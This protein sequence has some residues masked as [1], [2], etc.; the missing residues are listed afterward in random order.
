M[1]IVLFS[2]T[3]EGRKLSEA[4]AS[5]GIR[6]TVCV[7]T[8]LGSEL[9]G[10]SGGVTVRTGRMDAE[11]MRAFFAT[12]GLCETDTVVD[13][14]HPYAQEVSAN[15]RQA[16]ESFGVR[17]LT[18][19]RS[20]SAVPEGACTYADMTACAKAMDETEGNILLTTGSKELETFFGTI[21]AE[22]AQRTYVRVLPVQES[23]RLCEA[24]GVAS[25]HVIAMQGPFSEE[26]NRAIMNRFGIRHLVTKDGGEA[27]GFPEKSAA[28]R[29]LGVRLHMIARPTVEEAESAVS[30][31]EACR[32]LT[33]REDF[34]EEKPAAGSGAPQ[35]FLIGTGMGDPACLTKEAS[36]A[37]RNCGAVFGAARVVRG[38]DAPNKYEMYRA[39]EILPVLKKEKIRRA[40]ICF[41]G[42]A[43]FYSGAKEMK[44]ALTQ[45]M[46]DAKITVIP[47]V[48][49]VAYMAAKLGESWDDAALFSIHGKRDAGDLSALADTVSSHAKTF[50]LLSGAADI[51]KIAGKLLSRGIKGEICI[52]CDLSYGNET[53]ETVSMEEALS[54]EGGTLSVLMIRNHEPARRTLIPVRRDED[55]CRDKVPMTKECIRHESIIR[56]GLKEGDVFFDIGG[57]TGSVSVEAAAL[58][59]TLSVFTIE[60]KKEALDLIRKNVA[61]A[62]LSNVTVVEGTAPEVLRDLPKPDCVFIGGGSGRLREIVDAVHEKGEGIRFVINAVSLETV[63]EVRALLR[64]THP[65]KEEAVLISVSNVETAGNHHLMKAQNPVWIFSFTL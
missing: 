26:L 42:D 36:D 32:M 37:I 12:L 23:L 19:R 17:V 48:S 46:A 15:I 63:E 51:R 41:S 29:A 49:S 57:G 14:T 13:A 5:C 43:G 39:E 9:T 21:R 59:G 6:H 35:I 62:G 7:A 4:L 10:A 60:P 47:G 54:H 22:T 2:G 3:T 25:E 18:I 45:R 55:F 30:L 56:L 58:S 52:G 40:A 27:G 33:G 53:V 61:K 50:V 28:C 16:A 11:E 8:D 64:E 1:K 20:K 34:A 31:E 38:I 65:E 44:K 24:A